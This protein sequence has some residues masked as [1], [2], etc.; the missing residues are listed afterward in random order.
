MKRRALLRQSAAV[1]DG[2]GLTRQERPDLIVA[3]LSVLSDVNAG[4]SNIREMLVGDGHRVSEPTVAR[5]LRQLDRDGY[6]SPSGN[7]GRILTAAGRAHLAALVDSR[8]RTG[9]VRQIVEQ[10]RFGSLDDIVNI[11]VA[12][13]GVEREIARA[14]AANATKADVIALEKQLQRV[15]DGRAPDIHDA[16]ARAAHNAVLEALSNALARDP[17]MNRLHGQLAERRTVG[18]DLAFG[19]DVIDAIAKHDADSAEALVVRH[20]DEMVS[21]ATAYWRE[22]RARS[23]ASARAHENPRPRQPRVRRTSRRSATA[24]GG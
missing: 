14:A 13:R 9:N 19:R 4:A 20:L 2:R 10:L 22:V 21:V 11:L 24:R 8:H 17:D 3:V 16:L 5:L 12:R 23:R 7:Q 1:A 6:T 18:D 15:R